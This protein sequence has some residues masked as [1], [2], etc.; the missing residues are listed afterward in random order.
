MA[1]GSEAIY[2][3][4]CLAIEDTITTHP[5]SFF[6]SQQESYLDLD[7]TYLACSEGGNLYKKEPLPLD[8]P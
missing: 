3:Q 6:H 5:H 1:S 4:L 7:P 8:L 2:L